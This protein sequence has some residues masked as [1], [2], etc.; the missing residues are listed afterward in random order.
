MHV[1]KMAWKWRSDWKW[2]SS[3][4]G[5]IS[6]RKLGFV[7]AS[8]RRRTWSILQVTRKCIRSRCSMEHALVHNQIMRR[9]SNISYL[10]LLCMCYLN[11]MAKELWAEILLSGIRTCVW[12]E[13][14]WKLSVSYAE[15]LEVYETS[16]ARKYSRRLE[17]TRKLISN[18]GGSYDRKWHQKMPLKLC[19]VANWTGIGI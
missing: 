13:M 3:L 2:P 16:W 7:P 9:S 12:P 1:F 5:S 19:Y 18:Y 17:I 4:D 8:G 6:C 10:Y 15:V 11:I 14:S